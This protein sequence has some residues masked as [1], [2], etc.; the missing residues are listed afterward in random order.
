MSTYCVRSARYSDYLLNDI[1][2]YVDA[3]Y[4]TIADKSGRA[5]GGMSMGGYGA[6]V[7]GFHHPEMFVAVASHAGV[8]SLRYVGPHPFVAGKVQQFDDPE[9]ALKDSPFA[10]IVTPIF[11]LKL[12]DWKA[13]N[14]VDLVAQLKDGD[15]AIYLDAGTNDS[16]AFHDGAAHLSEVLTSAAIKHEFHLIEGGGHD[17]NFWRSRI[18][19]SLRFFAQ[20]LAP[21][22]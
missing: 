10:P 13:N 15:I 12:A 6:L 20:Y 17:A 5:I 11:G 8:A 14:P 9:A 21:A 22:H 4:R 2:G 7:N 18:D 16:F 19:D 1:I 3:H